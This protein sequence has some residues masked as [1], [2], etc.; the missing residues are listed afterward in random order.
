MT[1]DPTK[2]PARALLDSSVVVS[3]FGSKPEDQD[4]IEFF[5]AM[6][7]QKRDVLIAT[8]SLAELLRK[9][10]TSPLPKVRHVR[11]V[12]FD[13]GCAEICAKHFPPIVLREE[14]A[15]AAGLPAAYWKFDALIVATAIRYGAEC[16]VTRDDGQKKL[17]ARAGL[18]ALGPDYFQG[19]QLALTPSAPPVGLAPSQPPKK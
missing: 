15:K 10:P 9:R 12:A 11:A 16:I 13:E 1:I 6:V 18:M 7:S 14:A 17:A 4:A 19:A 3:A 5:S 2:L 8:V